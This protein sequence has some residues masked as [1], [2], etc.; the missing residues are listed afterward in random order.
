M[1][2]NKKSFVLYCDLLHTVGHLT[3]EQAGKLFKH[4]L[5]YVN[6]KDPQTDDVIINLAFE[7]IKQQLKRDL[8]K[9]VGEKKQRSAAGKKGMLKRWGKKITNGNGVIPPITNITDNVTVDVSVTDTVSVN[10]PIGVE[11]RPI[12][13]CL[14]I[15]LKDGRFVRSNKVADTELHLFNNYLEKQGKYH[16]NPADYKKYFSTLKDLYPH[17]LKKEYSIE[18]LRAAAKV[19]DEQNKLKAV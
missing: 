3:D 13:D 12:E 2:E 9:W 4:V 10:V 7:P 19:I 11:Q 14:I 1:A 17:L 8:K 16:M 5:N 6:D 15:A 18:E